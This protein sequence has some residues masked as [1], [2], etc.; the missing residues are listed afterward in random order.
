[1]RKIRILLTY[2]FL[3]TQLCSIA[4]DIKPIRLE[5]TG[6]IMHGR[7]L[8]DDLNGITAAMIQ[9]QIPVEG[10]VFDGSLIG[11]PQFKTN[12]YW[13][14]IEAGQRMLKIQCPGVPSLMVDFADI[15]PET[16]AAKTVYRMDVEVPDAVVSRALQAYQPDTRP[17]KQIV[18]ERFATAL[19][20]YE[21]GRY[22]AAYSTFQTLADDGHARAGV[23]TALC[24]F[25][26]DG[27]PEDA[28]AARETARNMLPLLKNTVFDIPGEKDFYNGLATYIAGK[29]SAGL[30]MLR[31]SADAGYAAAMYHYSCLTSDSTES[32]RYR[33]LAAEAGYL[34][35]MYYESLRSPRTD[36]NF[37]YAL[38]ASEGGHLHATLHVGYLYYEGEG[39]PEDK[40]EA[41]KWFRKAAEA[42][43]YRAE[44]EMGK[45]YENGV[46]VPRDLQQA[47][48]WYGRAEAH[49]INNL[50]EATQALRRIKAKM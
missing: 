25:N 48:Y 17:I 10:V 29:K 34:P 8:R 2:L 5:A 15:G 20:N 22:P 12:E 36:R 24:L 23:Y 6:E 37:D 13:V 11:D 47:A 42:G 41:V 35:G 7:M 28:A 16:V 49:D 40:A 43:L 33:R 26:G 14:W 19:H 50:G 27:T 18:A 32:R 44:W 46:S 30:K 4:A 31:K 9:V 38:R 39:V 3:F 1:M 45:C 21:T